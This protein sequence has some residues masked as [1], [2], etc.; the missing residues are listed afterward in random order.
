MKGLLIKDFKLTLKVGFVYY[1]ISLLFLVCEILNAFTNNSVVAGVAMSSVIM[2]TVILSYITPLMM[3]CDE[4][5]GWDKYEKLLPISK[6]IIVAEKY[7]F[8]YLIIA[9][10]SMINAVI[11]TWAY[12]KNYFNIYGIGSFLWHFIQTFFIGMIIPCISIPLCIKF[13]YVKSKYIKLAIMMIAVLAVYMNFTSYIIGDELSKF[14]LNFIMKC[15][16]AILESKLMGVQ[17]GYENEIR[18]T[19][20]MVINGVAIIC[21]SGVSYFLSLVFYKKKKF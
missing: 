7:I 19:L 20:S 2:S 9:G 3:L 16:N 8:P 17:L 13:G 18:A 14:L 1:G 15:V 4:K 5:Y 10:Y 21:M 12:G 6:K 11:M